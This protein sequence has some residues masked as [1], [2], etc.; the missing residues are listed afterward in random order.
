MSLRNFLL[1]LALA[2]W[3]AGCGGHPFDARV[4]PGF[5][6]V[7][8][9]DPA[10]DFRAVAP[11]GVAVAVRSE[12]L[13]DAPADVA[14]WERAVTLRMRELEGY[15]LLGARDVKSAD[16][17]AG[18]ELTFGHDQEGKPSVYRI[19]LFVRG[20]NL[21]IIEA[22]GAK[23]QMDRFASNVEWMLAQIQLR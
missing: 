10:Y 7:K 9:E 17:T 4:A 15:A 5:V 12:P 1:Y 23:E 18:R 11:E 2:A 14:F 21:F 3:M 22:G 19:R 16:G 13:K 20:S 8:E 6:E